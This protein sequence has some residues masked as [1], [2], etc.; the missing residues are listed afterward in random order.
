MMGFG[1]KILMSSHRKYHVDDAD[2]ETHIDIAE[3]SYT[4]KDNRL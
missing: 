3:T 4:E 1:H 2:G